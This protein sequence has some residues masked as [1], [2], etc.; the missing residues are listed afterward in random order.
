MDSM[1]DLNN[2]GSETQLYE[3]YGDKVVV[4]GGPEDLTARP[5]QNMP[6]NPP[7]G[8]NGVVKGESL[9]TGCSFTVD[10]GDINAQVI[11]P[12]AL[13]KGC[14]YRYISPGKHRIY[15][16]ITHG[17]WDLIKEHTVI[18]PQGYEGDADNKHSIQYTIDLLDGDVLNWN[19]SVEIHIVYQLESEFTYDEDGPILIYDGNTNDGL[20]LEI[21]PDAHYTTKWTQVSPIE[22]V[23]QWKTDN[24]D[25]P[26]DDTSPTPG[27]ITVTGNKDTIN[28]TAVTYIPPA[29]YTDPIILQY[30]QSVIYDQTDT[31]VIQVSNHRIRLKP[32]GREHD[33]YQLPP[34]TVFAASNPTTRIPLYNLYSGDYGEITDLAE[35]KTYSITLENVGL[36]P[37]QFVVNKSPAGTQ[38]NY[39]PIGNPGTITGTKDELNWQLSGMY[40][41]TDDPISS[42]LPSLGFRLKYDQVQTTD[43]IVQA[44]GVEQDI[45]IRQPRN[46]VYGTMYP[47][48]GGYFVNRNGPW[49]YFIY[50]AVISEQPYREG[51]V[52][53]DW[54]DPVNEYDG[55]ENQS[56]VYAQGKL[57]DTG[58]GVAYKAFRDCHEL[59]WT[60]NDVTFSDYYL[61]A[62]DEFRGFYGLPASVFPSGKYWLSTALDGDSQYSWDRAYYYNAK[63]DQNATDDKRS[64]KKVIAYRRIRAYT[65]V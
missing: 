62:I 39:T 64:V 16:P 2:W 1:R 34:A 36:Y 48:F 53:F 61:P 8:N 60:Y 38:S 44:D 45:E 43:N 6:W 37:G 18:Y 51:Y 40:Y 33:D 63:Y 11:W 46:L 58:D 30:E 21:R 41:D 26:S 29:D 24:L 3:D 32:S 27:E 35:G 23:G 55:W 65:G 19:L 52:D 7:L 9:S 10:V 13:P 5:Y 49:E 4:F 17:V 15:G 59:T 12:N 22:R 56:V 14:S 42:N 28:A 20:I 31:P 25:D 50:P 47:E 54:E 57:D